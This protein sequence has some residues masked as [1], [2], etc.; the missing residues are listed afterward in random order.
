LIVHII[1]YFLFIQKTVSV[2]IVN[3]AQ[4]GVRSMRP[5]SGVTLATSIVRIYFILGPYGKDRRGTQKS[6]RMSSKQGEDGFSS[7]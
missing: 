5:I 4:K 6:I 2:P 3:S 1:Y 7:P